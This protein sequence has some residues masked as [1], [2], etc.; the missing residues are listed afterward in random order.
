MVMQMVFQSYGVDQKHYDS[1]V[2]STSYLMRFI[3]Y[4]VPKENEINTALL[5]HTDKLFLAIVDQDEVEGLEIQTKD[6]E[7]IGIEHSPSTFVVVAGEPFMA[8]SN[9]RI[10]APLHR[11][12][13]NGKVERYSIALFSFVSEMVQPPEELVDDEHPLQFKPFDFFEFLQ[14][15]GEDGKNVKCPIR[16]FC[17]V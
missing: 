13:I 11:V 6:G 7:W 3:K 14:Y 4:R 10:Y 1:Q 9:G 5:P 2:E 8:W 16:A 12:V 15:C 17:G